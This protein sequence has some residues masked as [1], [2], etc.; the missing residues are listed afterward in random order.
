[1]H[2]G[3]IGVDRQ[4]PRFGPRVGALGVQSVLSLPLLAAGPTL[5]AMNVYARAPDAFDERAV[6]LGELFAVPAAISVQNA[7]LLTQAGRLAATLQTSLT[8][9]ASID[10]AVGILL[11]RTGCTPDEALARLRT[12]AAAENRSSSAVAQ[13]ILDEAVRRARARR[14][15]D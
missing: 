8:S 12:I 2:S 5:G 7:H 9:R 14:S 15:K 4:W 1:M 10:Q 13:A 11:S 3:S 6:A